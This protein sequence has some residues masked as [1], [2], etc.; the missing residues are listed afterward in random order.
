MTVATDVT[1]WSEKKKKNVYN[2]EGQIFLK[3]PVYFYKH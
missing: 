1:G 3:P 2:F